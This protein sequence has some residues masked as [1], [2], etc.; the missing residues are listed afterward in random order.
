MKKNKILCY[1]KVA[2][3]Y[4]YFQ[5]NLFSNASGRASFTGFPTTFI[6]SS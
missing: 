6:D 3:N 4:I 5:K 2:G 1:E